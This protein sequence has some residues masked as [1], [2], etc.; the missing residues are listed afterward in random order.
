MAPDVFRFAPTDVKETVVI[1]A[2]AGVVYLNH[3]SSSGV[4]VAQ[5]TG[6]PLL[7]VAAHT[8]PE[9]LVTPSVSVTAP[10]QSSLDGGGVYDTQ[11]LKV[12]LLDGVDVGFVVVNTLK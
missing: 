2:E 5:P 3:T 4:P 6:I 7:A 12:H 8:V 11:T 10:A 1:V 9:L